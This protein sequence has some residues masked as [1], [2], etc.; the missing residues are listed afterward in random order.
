MADSWRISDNK[1]HE[2]AMGPIWGQQDP[3]GPHVGPMNFAIWDVTPAN[4]S[5]LTAALE[6][7]LQYSV[8][9]LQPE[10]IRNLQS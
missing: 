2:T 7:C 9:T 5:S 3:G 1:V 6:D 8:Y 10:A 4:I